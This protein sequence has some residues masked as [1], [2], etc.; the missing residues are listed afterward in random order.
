MAFTLDACA[1]L[2]S[3][4]NHTHEVADLEM[5]FTPGEI[6][7][8]QVPPNSGIWPSFSERLSW[9]ATKVKRVKPHQPPPSENAEPGAD[10]EPPHDDDYG[11]VKEAKGLSKV[12]QATQMVL[13]AAVGWGGYFVIGQG[14]LYNPAFAFSVFGLHVLG[15]MS[16]V[17]GWYMEAKSPRLTGVTAAS[18]KALLSELI[19]F[20]LCGRASPALSSVVSKRQDGIGSLGTKALRIFALLGAAYTEDEVKAMAAEIEVEDG[21]NDEGEMFMRPGHINLLTSLNCWGIREGLHYNPHFTVEQIA[22]H[23]LHNL[24]LLIANTMEKLFQLYLPSHQ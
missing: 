18:E 6:Q 22:I 16:M 20:G 12:T 23:D 21:P 7:P 11:E 19:G 14:A 15:I 24:L 1:R 3:T 10:P 8:Q 4:G 13:P 5:G 17:V 2:F 9:W